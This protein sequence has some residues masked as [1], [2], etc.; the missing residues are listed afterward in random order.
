[1][2]DLKLRGERASMLADTLLSVPTSCYQQRS[3]AAALG[4]FLDLKTKTA[5]HRAPHRQCQCPESPA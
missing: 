3:L 5:L 4:L 1:M 2:Y